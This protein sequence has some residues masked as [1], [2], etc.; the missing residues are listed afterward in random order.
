[1]C[2]FID[3]D[4]ALNVLGLNEDFMLVGIA[5]L[6]YEKKRHLYRI[7]KTKGYIEFKNNYIPSGSNEEIPRSPFWVRITK[8][9]KLFKSN[10][11]FAGET[12]LEREFEKKRK[13]KVWLKIAGISAAIIAAVISVMASFNS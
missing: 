5:D 13:T 10:G 8:K 6:Q 3:F 2:L 12:K 7:F 9:G 11:G 4:E 1:M